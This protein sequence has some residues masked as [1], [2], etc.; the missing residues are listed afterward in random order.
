MTRRVTRPYDDSNMQR[1][2]LWTAQALDAA[3]ATAKLIGCSPQAVVAQAA[4]ETGWGKSAIGN[5][6]F[7]IKVGPTWKGKKQLVTTREFMSGQ[8]VTVQDWFRDYDTM[9]E[10]FA[11]HFTFLST[12]SRYSRVFDP[13][14]KMSDGDYFRELQKAGYATDPSYAVSLNAMLASVYNVEQRISVVRP[15]YPPVTPPLP[16]AE[17]PVSIIPSTPTKPPVPVRPWWKSWWSSND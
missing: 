17:L 2:A 6:V 12:N 14:D 8:Y 16:V 9:A 13:D 5:N 15:E 1:I 3:E 7:G 10:S 4:L 11:D